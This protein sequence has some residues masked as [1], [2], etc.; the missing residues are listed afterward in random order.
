M[1]LVVA[2]NL[3]KTYIAGDITVNAIQGVDFSIESALQEPLAA[4]EA[5]DEYGDRNPERYDDLH[6]HIRPAAFT[7]LLIHQSATVFMAA[8]RTVVIA[9][10]N[11]PIR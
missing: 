5:A 1:S 2:K 9:F 8:L 11:L 4:G 7:Q 10:H 3:K 6:R